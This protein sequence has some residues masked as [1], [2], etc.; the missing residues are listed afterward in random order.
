MFNWLR[1]KIFHNK[2]K[3]LLDSHA[4]LFLIPVD[5]RKVKLLEVTIF[6]SVCDYLLL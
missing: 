1:D 4:K 3:C 2:N 5:K 6:C